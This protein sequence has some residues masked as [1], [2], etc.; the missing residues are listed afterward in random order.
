MAGISQFTP[1]Q[2][3]EAGRRAEADGKRDYAVQFYQHVMVHHRSSAEA[4]EADAALRRLDHDS[5]SPGDQGGVNYSAAMSGTAPQVQRRTG[6]ANLQGQ[7]YTAPNASKPEVRVVPVLV[8]SGNDPNSLV[9]R[10]SS[11]ENRSHFSGKH[12]KSARRQRQLDRDDGHGRARPKL[13]TYRL[14]RFLA[15]L[16]GVVGLIIAT[17]GLVA[18]GANLMLWVTKTPNVALSLLATSP[19]VAGGLLTLGCVLILL[20][21]MTTATFEAAAHGRAVTSPEIEVDAD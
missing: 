21:Q 14:G 1:Q 3:L 20:A 19:T 5:H 11:R 13:K 8:D 15:S 2:V 10:A 16:L 18:L 17:A 7:R 12:S 9:R 6:A 4:P